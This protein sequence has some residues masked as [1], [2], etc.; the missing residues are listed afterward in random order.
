VVSQDWA[1]VLCPHFVPTAITRS[2]RNRPVALAGQA[3]TRSQVVGEAMSEKAV[4][5]GRVSAAE[6][7]QNVQGT[8]PAD[9]FGER[10][11]LGEQLRAALREG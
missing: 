6:V 9:A 4:R 5:S 3:R 7:A 10:P 11:E 1:N 2:E 8:N